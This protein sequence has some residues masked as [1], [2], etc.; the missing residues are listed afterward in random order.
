MS[1]QITADGR[2]LECHG[3]R[4]P[5]TNA[6]CGRRAAGQS[7]EGAARRVRQDRPGT[8][9]SDS[10]V[11]SSLVRGWPGLRVG[12]PEQFHGSRLLPQHISLDAVVAPSE[13]AN[14]RK[15]VAIS[16]P[17]NGLHGSHLLY[18]LPTASAGAGFDLEGALHIRQILR[19]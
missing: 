10:Q 5:A 19:L 1:I 2:A 18:T 15:R 3:H 17:F 11:I 7:G 12:S 13:V 4:V 16:L 14:Q 9:I 6:G 8:S